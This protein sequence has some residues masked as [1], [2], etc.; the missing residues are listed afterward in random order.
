MQRNVQI[1]SC[2]CIRYTASYVRQPDIMI[3]KC[4]NFKYALQ[5]YGSEWGEVEKIRSPLTRAVYQCNMHLCKWI[6]PPNRCR[7]STQRMHGIKCIGKKRRQPFIRVRVEWCWEWQNMEIQKIGRK[8]TPMW[9]S[10]DS[11]RQ[12]PNALVDDNVFCNAKIFSVIFSKPFSSS[13]VSNI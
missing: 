9:M 5:F 8:K 7:Q 12:N 3:A 10:E 1:S 2:V 6:Q 13:S 4:M 11:N